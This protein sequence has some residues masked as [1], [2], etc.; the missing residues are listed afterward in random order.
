MELMGLVEV[1]ELVMRKEE[2]VVVVLEIVD[3][4]YIHLRL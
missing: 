4:K 1:V 2:V 3:V